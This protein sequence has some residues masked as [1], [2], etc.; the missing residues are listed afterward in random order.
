LFYIFIFIF[1]FSKAHAISPISQIGS[2]IITKG[3]LAFE[4]RTGITTDDNNNSSN[5][6]RVF[7]RQHIN[8][9]ISDDYATRIVIRQN[10]FKG[11]SMEHQLLAWENH[12][13]FTDKDTHG[14]DSGIRIIYVD[15]HDN[16]GTNV[17]E[18]RYLLQ[19]PFL[20]DWQYRFNGIFS[21]ALG[22]NYNNDVVFDNAS[23]D[24]K[25]SN[26]FTLFF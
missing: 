10:K 15:T 17:L 5:H 20:T 1:I 4:Y 11:N 18:N 22:N 14:F 13:Q 24:C 19:I 26:I 12:V 6:Q 25:K 23:S 21:Y 8:Y 16:Y 2:P 3:E 9:G 7:M